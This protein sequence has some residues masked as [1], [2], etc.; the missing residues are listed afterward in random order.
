MISV[1]EFNKL[2]Y[3]ILDSFDNYLKNTISFYYTNL[4]K[5]S[6]N[7]CNFKF[8]I[9]KI[10]NLGKDENMNL[11]YDSNEDYMIFD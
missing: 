8:K 2:Q 11:V 3:N 7:A 1:E 5:I 4:E 6:L 9:D 10:N